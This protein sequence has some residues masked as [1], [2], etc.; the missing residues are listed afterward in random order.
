MISVYSH[1]LDPL[2]GETD[3]F[4]KPS[5]TICRLR[6]AYNQGVEGILQN[7]RIF[8][9]NDGEID[10]EILYEIWR[11]EYLRNILIWVN[12]KLVIQLDIMLGGRTR[13]DYRTIGV[14]MRIA[15]G[16]LNKLV[17]EGKLSK[18]LSMKIHHNFVTTIN[19]EI[20][21]INTEDLPF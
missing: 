16:M 19:G 5:T 17:N 12:K 18:K 14:L 6:N 2:Y 21:A 1:Y 11:N 20:S 10:D 13:K 4:E 7:A 3:A 8:A 15:T 9:L